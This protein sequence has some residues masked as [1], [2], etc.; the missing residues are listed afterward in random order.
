MIRGQITRYR[1][2]RELCY[3]TKL[4]VNALYLRDSE[5]S[6]EADADL[7]REMEAE[8]AKIEKRWG[9]YA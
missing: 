5:D 9:L 7:A 1:R 6:Y 2:W 3:A 4:R 8:A